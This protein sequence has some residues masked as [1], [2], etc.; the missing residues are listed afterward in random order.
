[1]LRGINVSGKNRIKMEELRE[2]YESLGFENVQTYVQSG[3]LIF[4]STETDAAKISTKIE[5]KI[6]RVFGF[7][8]PVFVRTKSEFQRLIKNTPFA[9]KD[10]TKLHVTFLSEA[11]T[12]LPIDELNAAKAKNEE[13]SISGKEIYLYC[14]N[15]YGITKLSNNFFERRLNVSATTRNWKTVSTLLSM[16]EK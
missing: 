11:P 15:G 5:K 13:F 4:E 9:G 3:N 6:E 14:P 7:D 2:L 8:V 10:T 16:A 12:N 1:M